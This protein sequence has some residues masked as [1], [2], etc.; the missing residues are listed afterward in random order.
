MSIRDPLVDEAIR[1]FAL[2]GTPSKVYKQMRNEYGDNSLTYGSISKIRNTYRKQILDKR[3][4]LS[5]DIPILDIEEQW[6]TLQT[7]MDSALEG[8]IKILPNGTVIETVDRRSALD[9]LKL[10]K[11]FGDTKGI[12]TEED[13]ELI[14]SIVSDLFDDL[15]KESPEKTNSELLDTIID[16]LGDKVKPHVEEIK[17]ELLYER[18]DSDSQG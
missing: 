8:D 5:A 7:I 13:D 6:L 11:E 17:Q 18:Q 10:A 4:E 14:K 15:K 3:K 1:L 9:C 2:Y 12:V 16:S